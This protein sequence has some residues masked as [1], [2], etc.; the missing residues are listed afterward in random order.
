MKIS[1]LNKKLVIGSANFIKKY[2]IESSKVKEDEIYKILDLAKKNGIYKF[3]TAEAYLKKNNIFKNTDKKFRFYTK[4]F[5]D[6]KWVSLEFCQKKIED[7][8]NLFDRCKIDILFFHDIKILF[9]KKGKKIFKNLEILKKKNFFKKI[10]LSIYD[11]DCLEYLN[12][13]YDFDAIQI[14]YNVLDNRILTSGWYSKL[15]NQGKE[16]HVRSIFL[17]G[18]L[19]NN[20]LYRNKYFKKWEKI[21][22]NWFEF[23]KSKNMS[24]IDYCLNDAL[25]N[26][27]DQIVI[28]INNSE[29]LK[30]IINFKTIEIN[31]MI[32]F[33]FNDTKLI[34]P[35]KWK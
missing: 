31:K 11:T 3:D 28:G 18:L 1:K 21:F 27:F 29:N 10:G 6:A 4:L 9:S 2:G 22:D 24:P 35:R 23:L 7:H 5:P 30:K 13:K 16:I 15:K 26:D 32:S 17:Q 20:L 34:D 33:R 12:S 8:L 19:V 25:T 14:P